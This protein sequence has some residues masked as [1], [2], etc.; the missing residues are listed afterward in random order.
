MYDIY[1][2]IERSF[3]CVATLDCFSAADFI[4]DAF[5]YETGRH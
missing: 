2:F 1:T 3:D 4:I 5:S